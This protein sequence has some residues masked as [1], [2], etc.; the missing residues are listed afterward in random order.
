MIGA[1]AVAASGKCLMV[2]GGSSG[3]TRWSRGNYK[4]ILMRLQTCHKVVTSSQRDN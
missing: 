3:P 2:F 4:P 1:T